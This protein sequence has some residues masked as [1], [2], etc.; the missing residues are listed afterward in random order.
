MEN[1]DDFVKRWHELH[2]PNV[3]DWEG[4]RKMS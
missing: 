2:E 4:N 1:I 3:V